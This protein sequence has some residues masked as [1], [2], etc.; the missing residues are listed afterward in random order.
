[1]SEIHIPEA[2]RIISGI[3]DEN[4]DIIDLGVGKEQEY[5]SVDIIDDTI[6]SEELTEKFRASL[7][8]HCYLDTTR[9]APTEI[10]DQYLLWTCALN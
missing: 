1:M 3:T 5:P 10:V 8:E 2:T 9:S 4:D 6:V 7:A